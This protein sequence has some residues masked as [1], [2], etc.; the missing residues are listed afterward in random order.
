VKADIERVEIKL[1]NEQF[2][3][4][5]PEH[6]VSAEREKLDKLRA[7]SDNLSNSLVALQ[8]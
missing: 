6:V 1:S 7:L 4:K 8:S 3:S 2:V 5:A